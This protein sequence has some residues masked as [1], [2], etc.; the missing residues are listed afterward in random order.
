[1]PNETSRTLCPRQKL[2][3]QARG[4]VRESLP[5]PN[6]VRTSP[7]A[8]ASGFCIAL[9]I[10]GVSYVHAEEAKAPL[11]EGYLIKGELAPGEEALRKALAADPASDQL[12]VELG[13]ILFFRAF[14]RLAQSLYNYGFLQPVRNLGPSDALPLPVN[15]TPQS[16]DYPKARAIVQTFVDDLTAAEAE[17]GKANPADVKLPIRFA[18]IRLDVNND[19]IASADEAFGN[20]FGRATGE[21]VNHATAIRLK[22]GFDAGDVAWLRGYCHLIMAQ[23]EFVL[24]YDWKELF[25]RTAQLLFPKVESPYKFERFEGEDAI[26][27]AALDAIAVIHL[28]RLPVE[29]PE[30]MQRSREHLKSTIALGRQSWKYILAETDDDGEWIP[31]PKQTGVIPDVK[32]TDEMI[33]EWHSFLD[34]ADAILDGKKLIPFWRAKDRGINLMKIFTAPTTFDLVLWV[35][36]TAALPYL[37]KGD[38]VDRKVW[39]KLDEA[40][41][42]N[43]FGFALWFN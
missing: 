36:G 40:F 11:V 7:L 1:M 5:V 23:G 32:V 35:Q 25:E 34:V 6:V 21:T 39:D 20:V 22:I 27:S 31:N 43:A 18:L 26:W 42:G 28:I 15:F 13:T 10:L 17:L 19:G 16:I 33:T 24:A 9:V 30:R 29:S 41:R 2:E 12:K 4:G 3:T 37:E 38:I 14:E 8:L